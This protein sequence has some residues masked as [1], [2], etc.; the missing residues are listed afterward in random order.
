[1]DHTK[2][3]E[4]RD[5]LVADEAKKLCFR[6]V[7]PTATSRLASK[8][9]AKAVSSSQGGLQRAEEKTKA[10]AESMYRECTF[11]PNTVGTKATTDKIL[12]AKGKQASFSGR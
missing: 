11:A 6:P 3:Q 5:R 1:Q 8:A 10:T 12:A 7:L 9:K 4:K 2:Q